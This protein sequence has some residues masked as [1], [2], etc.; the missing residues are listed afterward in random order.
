MLQQTTL[1]KNKQ[2][3]PCKS[4]G[5]DSTLPTHGIQSLIQ[6]LRSHMPLDTAKKYFFKE[7]KGLKHLFKTIMGTPLVV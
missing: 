6:E 7:S 2:G 1:F 5:Q 3:L 4:S